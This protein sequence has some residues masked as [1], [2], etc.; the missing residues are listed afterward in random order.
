MHF[1]KNPLDVLNYYP[2]I[3]NDGNLT[4]FA[5]VEALEEPKTDDG[6]KYCTTKL[7]I[8][9]KLSIFDFIKVSAEVLR[10]TITKEVKESTKGAESSGNYSQLAGG[11]DSQL[12]GGN[13]S[14]LAGGKGSV[15]IGDN[16]SIAKAGKGSVIVL[17]ERNDYFDII[18]FKAEL[19]DGE[20]IKED[21]WYKLID[22][23]FVEVRN[24]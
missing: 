13:G 23:E 5:E 10:K 19:V 7:K 9:A 1:C 6:K 2:L 16:G 18:N 4:E 12:A 8:S 17:V 24:E 3:D 14:Q 21:T 20:R 11:N 15:I 22:G